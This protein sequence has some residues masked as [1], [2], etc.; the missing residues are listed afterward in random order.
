MYIGENGGDTR[1]MKEVDIN[2]VPSSGTVDHECMEEGDEED[3]SPNRGPAPRK[4]LRLTRE[5]S[6]L[7]EESFRQNHTLNPVCITTLDHRLILF[8]NNVFH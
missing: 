7:L 2:Q 6:R 3:E 4:K 8:N 1:L 5:Q